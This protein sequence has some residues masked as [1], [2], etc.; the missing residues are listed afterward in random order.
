MGRSYAGILGPLAFATLVARGLLRGDAVAET[1]L[2]ASLGL[3]A[4]AAVGYLAGR[5]AQF[6][7]D[8]SV[9]IRF[10]IEQESD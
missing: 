4:M 9:R 1:M 10:Q 8:E 7:V 2:T 3:F 6:I 5:I